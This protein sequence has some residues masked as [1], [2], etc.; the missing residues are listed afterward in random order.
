MPGAHAATRFLYG[1]RLPG[2][3]A[4]AST[5]SARS[6]IDKSLSVRP[7]AIASESLCAL[8]CGNEVTHKAPKI[9]TGTLPTIWNNFAPTANYLIYFRPGTILHDDIKTRRWRVLTNLPELL[10]ESFPE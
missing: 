7:E 10:R 3:G 8:C 5:I 9:Q 6:L 4:A 2:F 1:S